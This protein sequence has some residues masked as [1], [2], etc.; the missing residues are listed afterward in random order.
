VELGFHRRQR[1]AVLEV[2]GDGVSDVLG[3]R[4]G[5]DGV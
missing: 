1:G 4:G 3:N 2:D 5:V